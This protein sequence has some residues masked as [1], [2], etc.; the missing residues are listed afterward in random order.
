[1]I[2]PL[3][4]YELNKAL[5]ACKIGKGGFILHPKLCVQGG[6]TWLQKH[7]LNMRRK[8]QEMNKTLVA[9]G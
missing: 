4:L 5:D 6:L 8:R 3:P 2:E 7:I 9:Q 1:M